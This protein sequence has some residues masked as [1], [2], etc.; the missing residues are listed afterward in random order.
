MQTYT[1]RK[2]AIT[3]AEKAESRPVPQ[4]MPAME[5]LTAIQTVD[6]HAGR[7]LNL[8]SAIAQRMQEKFGIRMDQVELRESSQVS[9]MD[10]RAFAKGNVVQFAPGQF[11]PD[12]RQGQHLLEHELAHVA[13]QARGNV[14]ADIP[15]LNVNANENLEQQADMGTPYAAGEPMSLGGLDAGSAPVQGDFGARIKKFFSK[16][17]RSGGA[18]RNGGAAPQAAE[19]HNSPQESEMV[20]AM[21]RQ[22]YSDAEI[23][24]QMVFQRVNNQP[25]E[26][27]AAAPQPAAPQPEKTPQQLQEEMIAVMRQQGFSADEIQAQLAF[28]QVNNQPSEQPEIDQAEKE[29]QQ[30]E[31]KYRAH[32]AADS[33]DAY[34][35]E[36]MATTL[37]YF[38]PALKEGIAEKSKGLA[39]SDPT[40]FL[41]LR[42]SHDALKPYNQ[43]MKK[44]GS[45][46][47]PQFRD[48][49]VS[50]GQE[51]IPSDVGYG[52]SKG[53]TDKTNF[54][55]YQNQALA[56]M[57]SY[58]AIAGQD[59]NVMDALRQSADAYS[60]LGEYDEKSNPS[61]LTGGRAEAVSRAMNDHLL[62]GLVPSLT[63]GLKVDDPNAKKMIQR[64]NAMMSMQSTTMALTR[65]EKRDDRTQYT[66]QDLA[67]HQKLMDFYKKAG[68]LPG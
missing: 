15:G 54:N 31:I 41:F 62:R 27:P 11:Q 60:S 51:N 2:R 9:D 21:R 44:A 56:D 52:P 48:Y 50:H 33:D 10:A 16:S 34:S 4:A 39:G 65:G 7:S 6:P 12:T 13:Q 17:K 23:Q 64:G 45:A 26:Q 67:M 63:A 22:G 58:L 59:E 49:M 5:R 66:E 40:R 55:A 3:P 20:A 24:A 46:A 14:Q 29:A 36:A 30:M 68:L 1:N 28:Q 61:G 37:N 8:D 38:T 43:M 53:L 18:E 32:A 35:P 57:D 42:G 19:S 47:T 25:S